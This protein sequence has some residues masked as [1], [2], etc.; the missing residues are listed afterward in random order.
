MNVI[1]HRSGM[2]KFVC[3]VSIRNT[4]IITRRS[5]SAAQTIRFMISLRF[6]V[7]LAPLTSPSLMDQNVCLALFRLTGTKLPK[8]VCSVPTTESIVQK[9]EHVSAK[10][11]TPSITISPALNATI[12]NI[13][14]SSRSSA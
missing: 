13:L 12:P 1:K 6:L 5:A 11:Q 8:I 3:N 10:M 14:I 7:C 2:M 4:G 9:E